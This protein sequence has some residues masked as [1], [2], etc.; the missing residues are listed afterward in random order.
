[1]GAE[2]VRDIL[3]PEACLLIETGNW[4]VQEKGGTAT[5]AAFLLSR[6]ND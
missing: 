3:F 4:A 6:E 2:L 1:M 5:G